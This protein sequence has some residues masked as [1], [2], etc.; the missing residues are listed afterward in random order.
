MREIIFWG[1]VGVILYAYIGFPLLLWIRGRLL[2]I[3]IKEADITP[4]VS[5]IITAHNEVETIGQKIDNILALDYPREKLEVIIASDGSDDGTNEIAMSYA[6][7]GTKLLALP[8]KGKIPTLNEA[9]NHASGQILVFSD[10]NSMYAPDAL[11]SLVRP[12]SDPRVGAVGGNQCYITN[13]ERHTATIG[14]QMY[15]GFDRMLKRMQTESGNMISATGAIHAIRK[16]LFKPL[17]LSVCDDFVIST[18]AIMQGYRLVFAQ[19]AVAYETIAPSEEAEFRRKVRIFVRAFRSLWVVKDLLNP[20]HYGFYSIQIFT[21]KLLRWLIGWLLILLFTISLTLFS[22]GFLYQ[23]ALIAQIALYG[24]ALV[25]MVLRKTSLAEKKLFRLFSIP[26]YFCMANGAA[27][28]AWIQLL[29]GK[30]IDVWESKRL[31]RESPK[32]IELQKN[33]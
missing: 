14:E 25:A 6:G 23:L 1:L 17:P 20:L 24:F 4:K 31:V 7:A 2:R 11:R 33:A 18:R 9:V 3:S 5:L 10:A 19:D 26:F 28:V 29:R 13:I 32:R 16:E 27:V 15:W 12:F 8:R 30:R 21:H 22:E